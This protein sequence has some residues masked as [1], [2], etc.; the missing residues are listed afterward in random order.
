MKTLWLFGVVALVSF[1]VGAHVK[2]WAESTS[3]ADIKPRVESTSPAIPGG[4]S[5]S[6]TGQPGDGIE[7]SRTIAADVSATKFENGR[8]LV[9]LRFADGSR[10]WIHNAEAKLC[11]LPQT[12]VRR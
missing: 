5:V 12:K 3:A 4:E 8:C 10:L 7:H 2:Q 9:D 11:E 6:Y 1:I